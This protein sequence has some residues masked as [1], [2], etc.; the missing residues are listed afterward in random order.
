MA[1]RILVIDDEVAYVEMV[2]T[3]LDFF[4]YE[5][6]VETTLNAGCDRARQFLPDLILLDNHFPE[7]HGDE[8]I[9]FLKTACPQTP[10]VMITANAHDVHVASARELGI[11]AVV[12]K[13]LGLT[14][15]HELARHYCKSISEEIV[16]S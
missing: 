16:K 7:G 13:P 12:T 2:Q 4:G 5:T 1:G 6:R 3:A 8:I 11:N 10:I 14:E 9:P 15:L